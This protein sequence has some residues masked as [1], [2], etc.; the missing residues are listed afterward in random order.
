MYPAVIPGDSSE[1]GEIAYYCARKNVKGRAYTVQQ[2]TRTKCCTQQRT[3]GNFSI[4]KQSL[5]IVTDGVWVSDRSTSKINN[6]RLN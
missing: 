2:R 3:V 4:T 5:Q 6:E 1:F